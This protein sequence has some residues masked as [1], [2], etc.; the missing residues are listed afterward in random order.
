VHIS[1]LKIKVIIGIMCVTSIKFWALLVMG[2][3]FVKFGV[4]PCWVFP[5]IFS[6]Y[7]PV[8]NVTSARVDMKNGEKD[9]VAVI[10]IISLNRLIDG[11]AA[12]FTEENIN[13]H[14]VILGINI[15]IPFIKNILRV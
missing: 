4:A 5:Y 10:N 9:I 12:I 2:V 13:H 14:I 15:I 3:E 6:E 8:I 1:G 11:G 7:T